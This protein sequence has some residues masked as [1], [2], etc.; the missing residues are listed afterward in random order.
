VAAWPARPLFGGYALV[1][2]CA[3]WL[4][5]IAV[6]P[7]GPWQA[8]ATWVWL[9]VAAGCA[10][11][12]LGL[13][14]IARRGIAAGARPHGNPPSG[15]IGRTERLDAVQ[16]WLV[17]GLV[18]GCWVAFG[19]ARAAWADPASDPNSVGALPHGV[20]VEV[21][22]DVAAEPIL[23]SNGRLLVVQVAS[24]SLDGGARWQSGTGRIE[25]HLVGPDDWFAPGYGDTLQLTGKL[26]PISPGAP[27]GVL[28]RLVSARAQIEARGG[29]NPLLTWLFALRV[30]LAEGIQ[31]TLPEPEA[32]LLIGILLG[33]KTPAL[34]ARLAL[35]TATGTIHL[36]VPAGLKVSLLAAIARRATVPL[37]R[38]IGTAASLLAVA[39][40][41]AL[42]GGGP[43]AVRAAIMGALLA[44]A[45]ALG[46]RYD[47]YAALALAALAMTAFE[48]LL[49]YDAGFQLTT[50][51]TLGIPLLTPTFQRWLLRPLGWAPGA[52]LLAPAAEL[53]AV[54]L[55]AQVAT[56]P[57]LALTFGQIS[58][59]APLANLL[60]VPLLAPLLVLGAALAG[61]TLL[62][63]TVAL[64]VAFA[65]WPLLWLT[66]RAIEAC[67]A[68]PAAAI[69]VTGAPIWAAWVYY[70]LVG[71]TLG[72]A[73][74]LA[75][76]RT[77]AR[78]AGR[79]PAA[80]PTGRAGSAHRAGSRWALRGL[81]ALV[82]LTASA[83]AVPALAGTTTQLDFLDVGSGGEATLLR[84][85]DGTTAL[86]DGGSAGPALEET[87]A[88]RLPF[89]QRSLDL[90][91]LTDP[92]PGDET[93]LQ[94]AAD[95]FAI[96]RAGDAGMLHPTSTY[97]AW[98]DALARGGTPH[99]RLR[100]DDVIQLAGGGARLRQPIAAAFA[101]R[102][103]VRPVGAALAY[104]MACV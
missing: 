80:S 59:V 75:G 30:R 45:P 76:R 62:A 77:R 17:A 21:R 25:V 11:A 4:A 102:R 28:A 47:V 79:P 100:Q 92:R 8:L 1:A 32:A 78:A 48:P 55:A 85:A 93:G 70:G 66:D 2:A 103:G 42:G 89:L 39:G 74:W 71:A 43:A 41:A 67:A 99:V 35:F 40:Y 49:I 86:I 33:L 15:P 104:N 23:E 52:H 73:L 98:L 50:L 72:V 10:G 36:V 31:R 57:V 20:S 6:W 61:A 54:T 46:R 101:A 90:A 97:L 69:P 82:V 68:L 34:R 9:A 18:L 65:T 94:D 91:L 56:L 60:V 53:L 7:V 88:A 64:L 37:G 58:L 14:L 63:P 81:A 38:W 29:G 27:V 19:A 12:A 5:G 51:A 95:H 87:L 83:A 96:G 22:G 26:A 13:R 24:F 16:R 84:L 44:L 3:A